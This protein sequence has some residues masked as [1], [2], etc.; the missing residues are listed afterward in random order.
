M[1]GDKKAWVK[2]KKYNAQDVVLLEKVYL[3]LRPWAK[4]HPNMSMYQEGVACPK[5]G[6]SKGFHRGGVYTN[7]TTQYSVW[8][9][10]ACRGQSRSLV[11][12]REYKP[13]LVNI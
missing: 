12:L 4:S 8:R 5:C 2:M 10:K 1:A 6:S 13:G 7:A 9:C 11:N 3:C